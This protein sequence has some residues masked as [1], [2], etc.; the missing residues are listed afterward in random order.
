MSA[1]SIWGEESNLT[2]SLI[3]NTPMTGTWLNLGAGDGRYNELLLKQGTNVLAADIDVEALK[4]LYFQTPMKSL[5]NLSL[6]IFDMMDAFP[7]KNSALDG[8]FSVGTIHLLPYK[9]WDMIFMEI[10]RTLTKGGFFFFGIS[11]DIVRLESKSLTQIVLPDE[12]QWTM[13]EAISKIEELLHNKFSVKWQHE[14]YCSP[15]TMVGYMNATYL[16]SCRYLLT[17]AKKI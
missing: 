7:I 5:P 10:H 14:G 1:N 16:F 4:C 13:K 9:N 3:K 2:T 17:G 11:T 12:Y 6:V 15:K 8:I